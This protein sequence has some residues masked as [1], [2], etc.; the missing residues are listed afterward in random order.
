MT[1]E[2]IE[3]VL[4]L[5]AAVG[6][7]GEQG[8]ARRWPSAFFSPS[9]RSFLSPLF[10]RTLVLSQLRGVIAAAARVHDERIGVGDVYHL[11]RLPE[12][13]EQSTHHFMSTSQAEV[14]LASS[15]ADATSASAT[16]KR[17]AANESLETVG[18]A[19]IASA[20]EMDQVT[21]WQKVAALYGY[22]FRNETEVYPFFSAR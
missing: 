11:F 7:L 18:P 10:P 17:L 8:P 13:I 9:S 14:V 5:R 16:L 12:D 2:I 20:K 4:R 22:G 15:S 3:T 21:A 6:L 1:R 19:R